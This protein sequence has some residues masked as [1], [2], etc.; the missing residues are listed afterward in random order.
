[1]LADPY[2]IFLEFLRLLITQLFQW[3]MSITLIEH[4]YSL[5]G[6]KHRKTCDKGINFLI[7]KDRNTYIAKKFQHY[8]FY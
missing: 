8:L 1:M 3:H 7:I 2:G 5:L 6:E 4:C